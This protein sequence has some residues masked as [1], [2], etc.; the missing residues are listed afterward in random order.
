MCVFKQEGGAVMK[1]TIHFSRKLLIAAFILACIFLIIGIPSVYSQ[2]KNPN[3]CTLGDLYLQ[4]GQL[5]KAEETYAAILAENPQEACAIEGMQAVTKQRKALLQTYMDA[6]D[7]EKAKELMAVL[8]AQ[9]LVDQNTVDNYRVMLTKEV[10]TPE[11]KETQ[12]PTNTPLPTN[13]PTPINYEIARKYY[14][15]NRLDLSYEQ[16][17]TAIV[18]NPSINEVSSFNKAILTWPIHWEGL[19]KSYILP[20][21]IIVVSG[22]LFYIF[23][24]NILGNYRKKF[25]VGDFCD[26]DSNEKELSEKIKT[27]IEREIL[28]NYENNPS[29]KIYAINTPILTPDISLNTTTIPQQVFSIMG[30]IL[31]LI[32]QRIITLYGSLLPY[33]DKRG[34]GI[35]LK[36]VD[37]HGR[38]IDGCTLYQDIYDPDFGDDQKP[39]KDLRLKKITVKA[40]KNNNQEDTAS[41]KNIKNY[42]P[43][44]KPSALWAFWYSVNKY[45]VNTS[46]NEKRLI[47][48]FGTTNIDSSI[49]NHLAMSS[50]NEDEKKDYLLNSLEEDNCNLQAL[51]N[52]ANVLKKETT[53]KVLEK[54]ANQRKNIIIE[55]KI[56]INEYNDVLKI[57]SGI[58]NCYK[59]EFRFKGFNKELLYSLSFYHIGEVLNYLYIFSGYDDSCVFEKKTILLGTF[60]KGISFNLGELSKYYYKK[61]F[62][63]SRNNS[64]I[65]FDLEYKDEPLL[66]NRKIQTKI[67]CNIKF[68]YQFISY[69]TKFEP[70]FNEP[71]EVEIPK[72]DCCEITL[73]NRNE[74]KDLARYYS[75][76][77]AKLQKR[78]PENLD[79]RIMIKCNE[80]INKNMK[81]AENF[82]NKD[83]LKSIDNKDKKNWLTIDPLLFSFRQWKK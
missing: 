81:V 26:D 60:E 6:G 82:I 64:K 12:E 69:L 56:F 62:G 23:A 61:S 1:K 31:K 71:I 34:Y 54:I 15:I 7:Y 46:R 19:I 65:I 49:W 48:V 57:F 21:L 41:L 40:I 16:L 32:P 25:D 39:E 47:K 55:Q 50:K 13:T 37:H 75:C 51:F 77:A 17:Q 35:A 80:V 18:L 28:R 63:F 66:I 29:E 73:K 45:Q 79:K 72:M 38:L 20:V 36:L 33:T 2:E 5:D 11:V 44:V 22:F 67:D 14:E 4:A 52:F 30:L 10:I 3:P 74:S 9:S 83:D 43:L 24:M 68:S 58:I 76:M 42:L 78:M 53:E 59:N 27:L 8:L 70:Q